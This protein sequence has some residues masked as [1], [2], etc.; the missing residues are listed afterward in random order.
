MDQKPPVPPT[1]TAAPLAKAAAL[2]ATPPKAAPAPIAK[3]IESGKLLKTVFPV[4][5]RAIINMF[6]QAAMNLN[7]ASHKKI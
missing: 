5:V 7:L 6:A 3:D 4:A 1:P 2:A